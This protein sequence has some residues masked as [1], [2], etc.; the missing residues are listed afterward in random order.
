MQDGTSS[1]WLG[2]DG[3]WTRHARDSSGAALLDLQETLT[4]DH[5]RGRLPDA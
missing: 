5:G 4:M 2:C 1:W 3:E